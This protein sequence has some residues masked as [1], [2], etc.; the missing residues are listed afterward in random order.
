[1]LFTCLPCLSSLSTAFCCQVAT[2]RTIYNSLKFTQQ[3]TAFKIHRHMTERLSTD[4]LFYICMS[5]GNCSSF[6]YLLSPCSRALLVKPTSSQLVKKFLAFYGNLSQLHPVHNLTS[7]FQN[8]ISILLSHLLMFLPNSFRSPPQ[9]KH[10]YAFAIAYICL[11]PSHYHVFELIARKILCSR[12]DHEV[13]LSSSS[14]SS[15][16]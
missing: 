4:S 2:Q 14:S 16:S 11:M 3:I 13:P 8:C 12:T 9:N 6:T 15:S 5:Y 7:L 10:I 1:M